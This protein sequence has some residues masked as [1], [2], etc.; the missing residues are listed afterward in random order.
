M[1]KHNSNYWKL[2]KYLGLG[3]SAH[4]FNLVTRQWNVSHIRRYIEAISNGSPYSE[5]EILD[6]KTKYNEYLMLSLRTDCGISMKYIVDEFG[7]EVADNLEKNIRL[8]R[9][10]NG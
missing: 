8:M 10:P 9:S 4:S 2:K 7:R 6:A 3:P 1:S 5:C